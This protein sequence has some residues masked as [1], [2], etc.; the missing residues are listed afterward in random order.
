MFRT[1]STCG[2]CFHNLFPDNIKS[3]NYKNKEKAV[4]EFIS[5]NFNQPFIYDKVIGAC[6]KRRPDMFLDMI[7]HVIMNE[8]DEN[9]HDGYNTTCENKRLMEL[10]QDIAHR[11]LVMIRFN[12]DAYTNADGK[13]IPSCWTNSKNGLVLSKKMDWNNRLEKLKETITYWMNNIPS[14]T[15]ECVYLFYSETE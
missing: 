3:R 8:V 6:S 10:S 14:K 12:P 2:F 15:I 1:E 13:R 11:P 4:A 5:Q 9:Q 7:T